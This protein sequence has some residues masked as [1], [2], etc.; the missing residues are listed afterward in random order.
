MYGLGDGLGEGLGDGLGE[1]LGLTLGDND[2]L[3]DG[4]G[5][6]GVDRLGFRLNG[7][8]NEGNKLEPNDELL[9][10]DIKELFCDF[11][12]R[13]ATEGIF[14]EGMINDDRSGLFITVPW[15]LSNPV[16]P[17]MGN[18]GIWALVDFIPDIIFS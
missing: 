18:A 14:L 1:G 15:R 5:E 9:S 4:L 16:I 17:P 2:R 8:F 11:V 3:G 12:A 10:G 7:G 13:L 6:R